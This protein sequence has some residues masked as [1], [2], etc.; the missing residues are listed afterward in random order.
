MKQMMMI[1]DDETKYSTFYSNS[2]AETIINQIDI[3][4]V[5]ESHYVTILSN[6]QQSPE[7]IPCWITDSVIDCNTNIS[8]YNP[9]AGSSYIKLPK[10]LAFQRKV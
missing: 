4:D 2:K 9:L 10:E 3:D 7:K 6:I 1:N 5:F 8:K